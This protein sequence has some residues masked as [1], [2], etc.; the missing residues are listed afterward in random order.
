[1]LARASRYTVDSIFK[2]QISWIL[3]VWLV[4]LLTPSLVRGQG[5]F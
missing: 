4:C 1:V 3:T 2:M 5:K